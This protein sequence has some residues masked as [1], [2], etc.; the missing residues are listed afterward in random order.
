[1]STLP[2]WL[3]ALV[4]LEAYHG[5]WNQYLDALCEYFRHDFICDGKESVFW[6][7]I[8]RDGW[9][10]AD[11]IPDLRQRLLSRARTLRQPTSHFS[12]HGLGS[13]IRLKALSERLGHRGVGITG[14]L[15]T[16][17]ALA[18]QQDDT[19]RIG[20]LSLGRRRMLPTMLRVAKVSNPRA[21]RRQ[22]AEPCGDI[23]T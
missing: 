23:S 10:V 17:V 7:I 4:T 20:E 8:T 5:D 1:M 9:S 3:P 22:F 19:V 15:Y 12:K 16:H 21:D 13:R 6:H 11:R 2:D 14:D 18:L